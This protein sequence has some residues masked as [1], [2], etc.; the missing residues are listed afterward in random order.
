M[1]LKKATDGSASSSFLNAVPVHNLPYVPSLLRRG[2]R[3]GW[4]V[5]TYDTDSNKTFQTEALANGWLIITKSINILLTDVVQDRAADEMSH[6]NSPCG[7]SLT[8]ERDVG[9]GSDSPSLLVEKSK[10]PPWR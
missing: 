3:G 8:L 7:P 4:T 1:Q 5:P 2:H 6:P 10:I 9:P